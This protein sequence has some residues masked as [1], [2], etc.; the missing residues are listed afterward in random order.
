MTRPVNMA[1]ATRTVV[2][3]SRGCDIEATGNAESGRM[4]RYRQRAAG[5]NDCRI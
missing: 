3:T 4:L 5:A 1:A 2:G